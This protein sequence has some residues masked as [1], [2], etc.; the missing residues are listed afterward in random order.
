MGLSHTPWCLRG[1]RRNRLD[2]GSKSKP[3]T[4]HLIV[5]TSFVLVGGARQTAVLLAGHD[6]LEIERTL[7][8]H[9]V[10]VS[11]RG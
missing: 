5:R 8:N 2:E 10:T 3:T 1:L 6:D 9:L 4:W 11:E 7:R